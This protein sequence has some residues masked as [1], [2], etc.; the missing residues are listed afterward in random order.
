MIMTKTRGLS[1]DGEKGV[2]HKGCQEE[3]IRL[4]A[5][6]VSVV[7]GEWIGQWNSAPLTKHRLFDNLKIALQQNLNSGHLFTIF[8]K[9]SLAQV[10][11]IDD[12]NRE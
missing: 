2:H 12:D 5:P 11:F 6:K 3:E 4:L 1:G 9:G 7:V 8:F 10:R